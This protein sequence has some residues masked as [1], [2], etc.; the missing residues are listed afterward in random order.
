MTEDRKRAQDDL[1]WIEWDGDPNGPPEI[2]GL[3][4][5]VRYRDGTFEPDINAYDLWP[6][7]GWQDRDLAGNDIVAYR[8]SDA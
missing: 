5:D 7:W 8:M 1:G 6:N 2:R 3:R 4:C